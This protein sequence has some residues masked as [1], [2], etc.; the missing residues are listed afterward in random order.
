[1]RLTIL[2]VVTGI[3]LIGSALA[4]QDSSPNAICLPPEEPFVPSGD[5]DFRAFADMISADFERYFSQ[6]SAYFTCMDGTRQAVFDRARAVSQ[7]HQDFWER[8]QK[9]GVVEKAA[10]EAPDDRGQK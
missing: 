7:S 6:L 2:A 9:L 8:A 5:D 1:M 4:A 10:A 3:G